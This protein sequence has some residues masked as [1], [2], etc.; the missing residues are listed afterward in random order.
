V[1]RSGGALH[2]LLPVTVGAGE[3]DEVNRVDQRRAGLAVAGGHLVHAA[4]QAALA[5]RLSHQHR[6]QWRD[7]AGLDDHSVARRHGGNRIAE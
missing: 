3:H 5:Q 2:H 4:R 1:E 6:R 7:L